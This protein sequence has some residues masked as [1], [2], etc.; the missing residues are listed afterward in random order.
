MRHALADR[1]ELVNAVGPHPFWGGRPQPLHLAI[2]TRRN[3]LLDLLLDAGADVDG[4]NEAYDRWS[5]L[6]LA[7]T[8]DRADMRRKLLDRGARVGLVEAMLME[9]DAAVEALLRPGRGALPPAPNDGSLLAFAR[10]PY[11]VDRLLAFGVPAD[12]PDHWGTRPIEAFSRLGER[13]KALVRHL[14][15]R[16]IGAQPADHARLGDLEQ[17]AALA[18]RDPAAVRSD[19]VMMGAVEAGHH[20]LVRWL[21]GRG[22]NPNAKAEAEESRHT[23]L[24]SAAWRGDLDMVKLLVEAGADVRA[25]DAQYDA[26]PSGWALTAVTVTNRPECAEVAAW[27]ARLTAD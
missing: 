5:P 16:G 25:R 12:L 10:T 4:R 13:G 6:M 1:P 21:L 3:D 8:P 27:L 20:D 7:C 26:P 19:A 2:E 14:Q 11:A 9:D 17:L 15:S 24:H 22:G 18:E 23:V